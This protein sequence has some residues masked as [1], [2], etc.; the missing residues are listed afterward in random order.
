MSTESTEMGQTVV[1]RPCG[2]K[3]INTAYG[4]RYT[5]DGKPVKGVTTVLGDGVPKPALVPWAAG[6]VASLVAEHLDV[7]NDG[8]AH[9]DR[10]VSYLREV[11]AN[12][13]YNRWPNNGA[14]NRLAA[15]ETLKG[16]PYRD[17]D[18]A[19]NRGTEVHNLAEKL[20]LGEEVHPPEEIAG[21]I[22]AYVDWW[23]AWQPTDVRP[24]VV[25]ASRKHWYVGTLDLLAV[26]NGQLWLVDIKT[27]RSGPFPE[28]ALQLAAYG[29]AEVMVLEGD[30]G[31]L[32]EHPMPA[33]ERYGV[34]WLRGDGHDF[35][36]VYVN[37]HT[38]RVFLY[39]QQIGKFQKS[40]RSEHIG[41]ALNP[42]EAAA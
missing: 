3:R 25:V 5:L 11:G 35:H 4:H 27:N 14:F 37:R 22:D 15:L 24:E 36:E 40:D 23:N 18:K 8:N 6:S 33:I 12:N 9:A 39:A 16:E 13:R 31:Q 10:L 34:L 32:H 20:T 7:D 1:R 30:D 17:R 28:V 42:P 2:V 29:N 19:A 41:P 21:H 38:F 26:I